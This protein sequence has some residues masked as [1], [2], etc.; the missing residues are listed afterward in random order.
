MNAPS[1]SENVVTATGNHAPKHMTKYPHLGYKFAQTEKFGELSPFMRYQGEYKDK[2]VILYSASSVDSMSLHAPLLQQIRHNKDF[3][4][5]DKRAILPHTWELIHNQPSHG[6]DIDASKA[7]SLIRLFNDE[8]SDI[9]F[10]LEQY[11]CDYGLYDH[12]NPVD[13]DNVDWSYFIKFLRGFALFNELFSPDSLFAEFRIP[14]ADI[15]DPNSGEKV[16]SILDDFWSAYHYMLTDLQVQ[17]AVDSQLTGIERNIQVW[18]KDHDGNVILRKVYNFESIEG[19]MAFYYDFTQNSN[20]DFKDFSGVSLDVD[21]AHVGFQAAQEQ[22]DSNDP[23][24]SISN[25]VY[26]GLISLFEVSNASKFINIDVIIA[27][28]LICSEFHTND[29]IDYVYSADIYRRIFESVAFE[30]QLTFDYNGV[31]QPYDGF[32]AV[33]LGYILS[34]SS[35]L[36]YYDLFMSLIT[37]KRSLRYI[38]YFTGARST[39]LSAADTQVEVNND[40]ASAIDITQQTL[41]ARFKLFVNRVGR[42]SEDYLGKLFHTSNREDICCPVKIGHISEVLYQEETQNTG[43]DQLELDNSRTMTLKAHN[44]RFAFDTDCDVASIII[45]IS[46]YE[47]TRF[48]SHGLDPFAL[49]VDRYD[50]FN[51]MLQYLGDQ[52]ISQSEL[53]A[54][55]DIDS[56]FGYRNKDMEYKVGISY[57][58]GGFRRELK[59]WI[60]EQPIAD[61]DT[62]IGPD[63]I[64]SHQTE[65]D[66]YYVALTGTRSYNRYHFICKYNNHISA[67]RNMVFAPLI[68]F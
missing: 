43:A 35:D 50:M 55:L 16:F 10:S 15:L 44:N 62:V 32:S 51:P 42:K 40:V 67:Y 34:N 6:D 45:G 14:L 2:N 19:R 9:L 4:V 23:I 49:K 31:K 5:V 56:Y 65:L 64:R 27:Y 17:H 3:Y 48:Y 46:S 38:D 36:Y 20:I 22:F 39:P 8:D 63:F 66:K 28:Q 59:D 26:N 11:I 21:Y 52:A 58:C 25:K 7:N 53:N 41:M 68:N 18:F 30:S 54:G 24:Y 29:L 47:I 12:S 1:G 60:F 57:S 61:R 37:R 13:L 33:T